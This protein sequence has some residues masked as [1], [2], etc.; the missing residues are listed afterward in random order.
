M[1]DYREKKGNTARRE[2]HNNAVDMNDRLI[3]N[4]CDLSHT[5]RFLY[6]GKGKSKTHSYCLGRN[7]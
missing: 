2:I 4:L 6:E 1:E 7:W 3:I 5:M